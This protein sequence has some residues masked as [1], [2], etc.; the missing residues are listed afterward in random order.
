MKLFLLMIGFV[1]AISSCSN[2]EKLD[3]ANEGSD[4][5][6]EPT[7]A[8]YFYPTDSVQP[9][10]YT[11]QNTSNPLDEKIFRIYRS[12]EASDTSLI[13]ERYN[14]DFKITEGFTHDLENFEVTDHMIVDGDGLKRQAKLSSNRL[15]PVSKDDT[16][17]F[18]SD[19]PSHLDSIT[20][21]YRSKRRVLAEDEVVDVLGE[22][23]PALVVEDSVKWLMANVYTKQ[24]SAQD[25]V[26]KR[27][28]AKGY[29]LVKWSAN[30]DQIVY[31]LKKI[32]SNKWWEE[33][34][35]TPQIKM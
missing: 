10:I 24:S 14:A 26:I 12:A 20:M 22:E 33:Y 28:F 19:F 29:G 6:S 16:T 23:I 9:Y 25:I 3:R 18:L 1:L 31:K 21:V 15:F 7:Y 4:N 13:V 34:A 27:Y 2:D 32:F 11:F 17:L 8:D 5:E 35:R 30:D